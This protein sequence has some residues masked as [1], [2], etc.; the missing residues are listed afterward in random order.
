VIVV[1]NASTDGTPDIVRGLDFVQP[2][3][4]DR[5]LGFAAA[6]SQA[7]GAARGRYWLL[8]NPDATL[9]PGSLRALVSFMERHP[10]AGLVGPRLVDDSGAVQHCAQPLPS[11]FLT[12]LEASRLHWL[13][14]VR[15]RGRLLLGSYFPHDVSTRV[16]WTWG[17]ALLAR[18][19]AVA[20]VGTLS[21][22]FFMYGEDLE[23]GL[24][25]RRAGW[26]VWFCAEAEVRHRGAGSASLRWSD[27][28]RRERILRGVDDAIHSHRGAAY[29][30]ALKVASLVALG[31]E[32]ASRR[33]RSR[34]VGPELSSAL[35]YHWRTLVDR[36]REPRHP[37]A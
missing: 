6:H 5:N 14:P 11:V 3:A 2:M 27:T 37:D 8:L 9:Q 7:W 26:E 35:R 23:W 13:L 24:R 12:V 19:E 29:C 22:R 28:Q 25:M 34:P 36:G 15:R 18:R 31:F 33:L 16:G 4:N 17:T 1:D 10:R 32:A 20:E 21:E 30:R